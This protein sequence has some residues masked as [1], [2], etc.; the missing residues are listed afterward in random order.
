VEGNSSAAVLLSSADFRGDGTS[1]AE[2]PVGS[3]SGETL[4]SS[5]SAFPPVYS[6]ASLPVSSSSEIEFVY[7]APANFSDTVNGAVFDMVYVA[8][9]AYTRGCDNCAEQDKIYETPAHKVTV[10][11]YH[12]A[13]T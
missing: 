7:V 13:S 11:D 4:V 3:S 5:S 10:G 12:V 8:G 2:N 6:S 1:S 9:G